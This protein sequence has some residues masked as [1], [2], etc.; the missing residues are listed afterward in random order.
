MNENLI[1]IKVGDRY[2]PYK[3][4]VGSF[5]PN[6]L[7]ER[8]DLSS[9]DKLVWAKLA[10]HNGE[11]NKCYPSQKKIAEE[12]GLYHEKINISIKSLC[13]KG[14]IRKIKP[15][16]QEILMHRNCNYEFI[17]DEK[18][19]KNL[20]NSDMMPDHIGKTDGCKSYIRESYI[21]ESCKNQDKYKKHI[22]LGQ[23]QKDNQLED[24]SAQKLKENITPKEPL[25]TKNL[26]IPKKNKVKKVKRDPLFKTEAVLIYH[27]IVKRWP[28]SVQIELINKEIN[29]FPKWEKIVTEW[30]ERGY[31]PVN[32]RG[33]VDCYHNGWDQN[34]KITNKKQYNK[35]LNPNNFQ[36]NKR[37]KDY[38]KNV[39]VTIIKVGA[40]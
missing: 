21:K 40:S 8:K 6:W 30:F 26:E 29:D 3:M 15:E 12:L 34:Y 37:D 39:P 17:M 13:E 16:G 20:I 27:K 1:G 18:L 14:L 38:Y 32:I 24:S 22:Y 9:A 33:I 2:N 31:K 28:N 5:L 23:S 36:S 7:L 25:N 35:S 10:Q 11:N 19:Y 4:F